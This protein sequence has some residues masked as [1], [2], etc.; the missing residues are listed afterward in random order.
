MLDIREIQGL[1]SSYR[2]PTIG[3]I[4]SHSALEVCDGAKEEKIRNIVLCKRGREKTYAK[5]YLARKEGGREVGCVDEVMIFEEWSDIAK[6]ETVAELVKRQCIFVPNRSFSVYVGYENIE[7]KFRVPIFGNRRLLRAEERTEKKNQRWLLEKAGIPVPEVVKKP[8]NIERLSIVKAQQAERSYERAFFFVSSYEEYKKKVGELEEQGICTKKGIEEALIEEV[9][10][11]AHFNFNFFY[12]PIRKRLELLGID[13]RR[14]TS[15]DGILR[16]PAWE[17][18]EIARTVR[19]ENIEVGH[20]ACTLRE[21]LLEKVFDIGE[22]L[23][24]VCKEQYP[25]GI[26]G[27]FAMQGAVVPRKKSEE[28]VIFDIS[29]RMP[30]SPGIRFTPYPQY[31]YR[32]G[33]SC[34]R[35]VAREISWAH[36]EGRLDELVT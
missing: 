14:Q 17:Q 8:E 3:V 22:R 32:E 31:L 19:T 4:G 15:L 16:L 35:R 24:E 26:I 13:M 11:G 12:S 6:K 7:E 20:V 2:K 25:P 10:L 5:Y 18:M 1:A 9:V 36:R 34:G 30:G 28:I 33:I 21:S 27:A 29:F 23:L